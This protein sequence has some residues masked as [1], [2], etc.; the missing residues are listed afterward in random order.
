[1]NEQNRVREFAPLLQH[2]GIEPYFVE[3]FGNIKKVYSNKGTFA[4]KSI[5]AHTGIDFIR[6]VQHLYQRGYNRIVPIYPAL[7]GRYGILSGQRLYYL[8]PW[9]PNEALQAYRERSLQMIR[10]LARLHTLSAKEVKVE[11][12]ERADHFEKMTLHYEKNQEFLDGFI[13]G[14][15]KK[16]YMSP[17]EL[18]FCLYYT[19]IT[20]AVKYSTE[21]LKEWHEKSKEEEKARMVI[22]H[23]KLKP[24][25]FVYNENGYGYFINFERAGYGSPIHDLLPFISKMLRTPPKQNEEA[26]ETATHYFKYFPFKKDEKLLFYS[27]L[28]HPLQITRTAEAYFSE[29]AGR[30]EFAYSKKLL[31]E[32]WHLKNTEYVVMRLVEMDRQVE[33]AKEGAQ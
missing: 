28:A 16:I 5:D 22:V 15:E 30:N 8:M 20:Q 12:E 24:E 13:E 23:G 32:Y 18:Q 19:E 27:Y 14:C 25:H 6:H 9:L 31:K 33:A 26:V 2:Y 11:K 17:F 3:D 10:E 21:K 4:L 29:G 7:D 1:M